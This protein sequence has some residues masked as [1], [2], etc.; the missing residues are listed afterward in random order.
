MEPDVRVYLTGVPA[1]AVKSAMSHALYEFLNESGVWTED[2]V[3]TAFDND[4]QVYP[5]DPINTYVSGIEW[6]KCHGTE[7]KYHF[8]FK[9]GKLILEFNPNSKIDVRLKLSNNKATKTLMIPD[10]I[11]HQH[12]DALTHITCYKLMIQGGRPWASGD[13]AVFHQQQYRNFL[14]DAVIKKTPDRVQ[15]RP[16]V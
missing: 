15:M 4:I 12:Q 8:T 7:S 2:Q 9:A 6:V 5:N 16:F 11:Y 13:G 1:F 3:L 10:W 14:G